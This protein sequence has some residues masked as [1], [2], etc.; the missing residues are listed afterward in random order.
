MTKTEAA[1]LTV[2]R[3]QKVCGEAWRL[4]GWAANDVQHKNFFCSDAESGKKL[5]AKYQR[6]RLYSEACQA[7]W[8]KDAARYFRAAGIKPYKGPKKRRPA[9]PPKSRA[10]LESYR[11]LPK[12]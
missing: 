1:Y 12:I 2:Q 7:L 11:F 9:S 6:A 3:S 5:V 4:T 10:A 8:R